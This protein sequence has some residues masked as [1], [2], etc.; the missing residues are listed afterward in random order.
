MVY[1]KKSPA[2]LIIGVVM[3]LW[4]WLNASGSVDGMQKSL[5]K[6]ASRITSCIEGQGEVRR[7]LVSRRNTRNPKAS[8]H[9]R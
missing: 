8:R 7:R 4:G 3:L 1:T 6:S 5:Q 9:P 2:L